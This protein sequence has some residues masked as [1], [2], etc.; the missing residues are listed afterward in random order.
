[1]N[2]TVDR[3]AYTM[4]TSVEGDTLTGTESGRVFARIAFIIL[5]VLDCVSVPGNLVELVLVWRGL[6]SKYI[7][8]E[9]V[10]FCLANFSVLGCIL[11]LVYIPASLVLLGWQDSLDHQPRVCAALCMVVLFLALCATFFIFYVSVI[12][13]M[14]VAWPLRAQVM[15]SKPRLVASFLG[16]VF[17]LPAAIMAALIGA[18]FTSGSDILDRSH[19]LCLAFPLYW[20]PWILKILVFCVIIPVMMTSC[21]LYA[22]VMHSAWKTSRRVEEFQPDCPTRTDPNASTSDSGTIGDNRKNT[23]V[24]DGKPVRHHW[25]GAW[26]VPLLV[27][28]VVVTILPIYTT[29]GVVAVCPHCMPPEVFFVTLDLMFAG[30]AVGPMCDL[31]TTSTARTIIL[32]RLRSCVRR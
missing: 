25:R 29:L 11:S 21:L 27:G 7:S 26:L 5:I 22:Y 24:G 14:T 1:M 3:T 28:T 8:Q 31:L 2:S 16:V 4:T 30:V 19:L 23:S 18:V 9:A 15:L 32:D 13:N 12:F 17:L 20:P 6:L 10:R